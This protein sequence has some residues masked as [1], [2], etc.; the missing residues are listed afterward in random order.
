MENGIDTLEDSLAI[1]YKIKYNLTILSSS[2]FPW[3]LPKGAENLHAHKY[4]YIYV[5]SSFIHNCQ[6]MEATKI[7]F[8]R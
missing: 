8:R 5:Y 4:V 7:S 2:C 1:S 6:K 3:Y